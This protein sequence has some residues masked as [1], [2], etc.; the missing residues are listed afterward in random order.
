MERFPMDEKYFGPMMKKISEE[1]DRRANSELKKYH[2]TIT[3]ARVILFLAKNE[4]RTATQKELEDYLRVSHPTTVTILKSMEAKKMVKTSFDGEDRRM[5]NVMLIW[6]NE[7]IY[8]ELMRNAENMETKLLDGFSEE[9]A[10]LFHS[11]LIRAREN[12]AR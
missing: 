10:E 2:L 4:N 11:F 9:E 6:G 1:M 7:T 5:K 3:Q 12:A 8:K